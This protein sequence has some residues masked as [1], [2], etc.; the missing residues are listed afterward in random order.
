MEASA[1]T[2]F[3]LDT[4]LLTSYDYLDLHAGNVGITLPTL[5][6]HPPREIFDYFGQPECT[7]ILPTVQP[8]LPQALPP[9]LV[10]PIS[11]IDYLKNKDSSF[12]NALLHAEIMDLGNGWH[13][14]A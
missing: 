2:I 11:V 3:Q 10:P 8:A 13:S 7:I 9:Y 12:T 1:A 4:R 14:C 5:N 6:E